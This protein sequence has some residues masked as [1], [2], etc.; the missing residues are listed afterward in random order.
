MKKILLLAFVL[1][2]AVALIYF[3]NTKAETPSKAQPK[4]THV[5]EKEGVKQNNLHKE[6]ALELKGEVVPAKSSDVVFKV[7][8]ILE[9]GE[10]N[11]Q[12]GNKFRKNQLLFQVNNREA[13][14]QMLSEKSSLSEKISAMLPEI[15]S[16][17][18]AEKEK[19]NP[20]LA[21]LGPATL[22][23]DLPEVKTVEEEKLINSHGV[24]EA[25]RKIKNQEAAM[26]DYFYIAPFDGIVLE[27]SSKAGAKIRKNQSV[28]QIGKTGKLEI[29]CA[30]LDS[31]YGKNDNVEILSSNHEFI[32]KA[33]YTRSSPNPGEKHLTD[34]YFTLENAKQLKLGETV[35]IAVNP[36]SKN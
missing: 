18:P 3:L 20:F 21:S 2:T 4:E 36:V 28:A 34:V 19:W 33:K 17:F 29:K 27:R 9:N 13:F 6:N 24:F 10:A 35:I 31:P 30:A 14:L 11:F 25:Y 8:G 22:I 32:S 1:C 23:G 12:K 15:E 5:L 16:R 26:A 7:A